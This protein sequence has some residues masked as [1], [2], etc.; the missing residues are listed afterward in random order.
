MFCFSSSTRALGTLTGV[1]LN[2]G[3]TKI[4]SDTATSDF[5]Q[6]GTINITYNLGHFVTFSLPGGGTFVP[7]D[8]QSLNC[9]G[10]GP[11]FSSCSAAQAISFTYVPSTIDLTGAIAGPFLGLGTFAI[12]FTPTIVEDV[13]T[14]IP[15]NPANLT[16]SVTNLSL[17]SD[18]SV[19]YT[20]DDAPR[21]P[22]PG[23]LGAVGL[24]LTGLAWMARRR[25]KTQ[26]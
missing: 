2:I 13:V 10:Q 15:A 24:G 20:F 17:T 1:T 23:S 21:T 25:L 19:T 26:A 18:M 8:F 16:L 5:Q 6:G 11:E 4:S 22:E 7:E 12:P 14:S 3:S 9:L